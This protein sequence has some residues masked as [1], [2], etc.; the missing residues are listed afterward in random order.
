MNLLK[1]LY[2]ISFLFAS[3]LSVSA[4]IKLPKLIS[5]GM[6]LQRDTNIKI[7]GWASPNETIEVNFINENYKTVADSS[8]EWELHLDK[9]K[10]GGPFLMKLEGKN[11]I[12]INN[13][14]VGDVWLASGQ[15]N[16]AY[17]LKKS[18]KL[19]EAAIENSENKF[20]RQF[21]VPKK[22]NFKHTENDVSSGSW[23]SANKETVIGFSAVAY[24]FAKDLYETYQVP[25]GL[26]NSSVGGTPAQA[27]ISE[28]G[29]KEFPH[30]YEETQ[31]LKNDTYIN[32]IE[33]SNTNKLKKWISTSTANDLGNKNSNEKWS[34]KNLDDSD[35]NTMNIPGSWVSK[36]LGYTQGIVWYRKNI[37]LQNISSE[38]NIELNLG[39][40]SDAD[41]VFVNGNFVGATSHKFS[42]RNYKI[43]DN[44][45]IK[46]ENNITIRISSYRFNGGFIKGNPIQLVIGKK[47]IDLKNNWKYKLG[48][49]MKQLDRPVQLT[50]KP[51]GLYKAMIAPLLNY[52]IKGA[53]WYQ[54]EGNVSKAE[55]YE[56]LFP[57]LIEDWRLNFQ[58]KNMPF[59]F[60]QLANFQKPTKNLVPSSW[61]RLR[62]S[63]L[64]TLKV[65]NTGMAVIIDIGEANDIHPKNKKDVGKRLAIEAKRVAYKAGGFRM[66]QYN[67]MN[68]KGNKIILSFDTNGSALKVRNNDELKE[69]AI[70]G[71]D[72]KF[73]WAKAEIQNNTI[74]V[75]NENVKNPVAVRYAWANNPTKANLLAAE[76]LP[77]SPFRTD[78]WAK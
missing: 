37:E 40:I 34:Q 69:F 58:H 41:S 59:L 21:L 5:N 6:V 53:I 22:Y 72:K 38:K 43:P 66:P 16:M 70:S 36:N 28:E 60:V 18:A 67:S 44:I 19:Y 30:Y 65:E 47:K 9:L 62:A 49:K 23:I 13:I 68:I 76:E 45:L 73:V 39:R 51:T 56:S 1:K 54:G 10:A 12:E 77:L 4:Q 26:I 61:A 17:E 63:Q 46:G 57:S 2:I 35:W 32:E 14:L 33:N 55:E 7:W 42:H 24:F 3:V 50:C 48:V 78:N 75:W 27:W 64:K 31:L 29:L 71:E 20:I 25:I 8:G 15:S 11:K 74:I 52:S